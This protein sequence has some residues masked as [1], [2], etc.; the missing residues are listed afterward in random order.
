MHI[1]N[2]S[3]DEKFTLA[4]IGSL[5]TGRNPKVLWT[6]LAKLIRENEAFSSAFELKLIGAV[7]DDVLLDIKQSDLE[8]HINSVGYVAHDEA[9]RAQFNAQVLLLIEIDSEETIGILPGKLFEYMQTGRPILAF[10][11]QEA[12]F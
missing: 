6:V 7:S 1:E 9:R 11:P 8:N 2:Q 10:G 5:L 12:D 3:L 4:H